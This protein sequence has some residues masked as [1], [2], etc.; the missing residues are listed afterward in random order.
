M[1]KTI[2][3]VGNNKNVINFGVAINLVVEMG[4]LLKLTII[5][6]NTSFLCKLHLKM[7]TL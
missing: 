1:A 4:T 7:L 6:I 5:V 2:S 3:E